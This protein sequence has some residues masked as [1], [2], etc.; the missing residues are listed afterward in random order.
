MESLRRSVY[1]IGCGSNP[2]STCPTCHN[3]IPLFCC[4]ECSASHLE[5][6]NCCVQQHETMPL[7]IVWQWNDTFFQKISLRDLGLRVQLATV[8]QPCLPTTFQAL[9]LF[10]ACMLTGKMSAFDFYKA[11]IY[12]IDALGLDIP[13]NHYKPLLHMG[14]EC[15]GASRVAPGELAMECPACPDP[16]VNLPED[17]QDT[18]PLLQY[19]GACIPP[20]L[21]Y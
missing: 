13:K 4:T 18:P 19:V 8:L 20:F 12:L 16:H 17:W 3:G 2:P 15:D 9:D 5:C 6:Q 7:H 14:N 11:M 21:W 10:M 1:C